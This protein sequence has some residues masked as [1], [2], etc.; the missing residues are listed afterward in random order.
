MVFVGTG[1]VLGGLIGLLS[2][3]IGRIPLTL[4]APGGALVMGLVFGWLRSV[5]PVESPS[6]QSG[7]SIP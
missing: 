3:T 4:T 1:I 5:Y 7:S 2:V 6:Q